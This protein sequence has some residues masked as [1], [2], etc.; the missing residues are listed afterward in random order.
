MA[1]KTKKQEGGNIQWNRGGT[2]GNVGVFVDDIIGLVIHSI[3]TFTDSIAVMNT[4]IDL[5]GDM[6]TAFSEKGAPQPNEVRI[7]R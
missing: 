2:S 3:N 6:G 1:K 7:T 4:V 5:P